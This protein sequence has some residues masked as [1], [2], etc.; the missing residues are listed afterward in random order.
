[1]KTLFLFFCSVILYSSL[2]L[3]AATDRPNVL[4]ILTDDQGYGDLS[5]HGNPYLSTTS[6]DRI[7]KEGVRLDRFYV[8]PVCAPTRASLMTGRY[9]LRTGAFGVTRREEVVNPSETTI[10]ELMRDNGYATGCFGKWHNG[11]IYPETPNGQ[12]FQEFLGFLGGLTQ[13]YFGPE[14]NH[15]GVEDDYEGYVTEVLAD[16]A[17]DWMNGQVEAD[18]PFFC[19]VPFNAPHTPGL[20]DES[21]WKPFYNKQAGR[22]ESVIFGMI[23]AIDDQV[24]KILKFLEE[25]RLEENTIV[26]FMSDNGPATW[27]Y[28]AGLKGK[29]GQLYEGGI[30]VPCFIRWP[31]VLKPHAVGRPLS[32]LDILPTLVEWCEL[33]G[34]EGLALDGR[35]FASLAEDPS[36]KWPD[37]N[38]VS[39]SQGQESKIERNGTVHSDQWTAVQ[40]EG[41]WELYDIQA[42][43]RQRQNVAD[44]HPEVVK[45]LSSYFK[46]T[47]ATMPPLGKAAPVP[48]GIEGNV[49]VLLEGQDA[50]LPKFKGK[51]IDYNYPAGFSHHWI[52]RWTEKCLS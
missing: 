17:I 39:F 35:S 11:S 7:G 32:H 46:A 19:Y 36:T 28:N 44:K 21:Y 1:M 14:L 45:A 40:Q 51:G 42:D 13:R 6:M 31:G 34:A 33:K 52:S 26:I 23:Q 47:L 9:H 24:G 4:L 25:K 18:K 16:A 38:F 27:R 3:N 49:I 10:A 22:W 2:S 12:G 48:V 20:V 5:L 29:K 43:V 37:R 8:S 30:R 50:I 15:N 41:N